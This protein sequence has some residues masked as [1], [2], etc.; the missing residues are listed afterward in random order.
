MLMVYL[1][2]LSFGCTIVL[3]SLLAG[4]DGDGDGDDDGLIGADAWFPVRSLRF[5]TVYAAF[6]GLTGAFLTLLEVRPAL[7][8]AAV[9]VAVGW[10][11]GAGLTALVRRLHRAA[12]SLV[13][14][15]DLTGASARVVL[16]VGPGRTGKVR[17]Q[18]KGR[19][20]ERLADTSELETLARDTEVLVHQVTK[21]G[22]VLIAR[23]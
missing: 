8:V 2:A 16:P 14:E 15:E 11:A 7:L 21:D 6:M 10:L 18:L 19:A 23:A 12:G 13:G 1:V 4:G 9:A 17:L 5:W 3:V 20:V 22:R